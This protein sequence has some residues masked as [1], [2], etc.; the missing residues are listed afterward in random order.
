MA[1]KLEGRP[2]RKKG[3]ST[4]I[5]AGRRRGVP[6]TF[7]MSFEERIRMFIGQHF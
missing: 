7:D 4:Q 3:L 5:H 2:R 6:S 1:Q